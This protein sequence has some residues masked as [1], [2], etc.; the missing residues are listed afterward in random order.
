[1]D[2][3]DYCLRMRSALILED[4]T[5]SV[6]GASYEVHNTLGF[7][8]VEHLYVMAL[9]R[10]LRAKGHTVSREYAVLVEYK[11]EPLGHSEG[12]QS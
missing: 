9:E 4:L 7:G 11:G 5:H 12:H 10:E 2:S 1:M 3:R 6:I 8:F